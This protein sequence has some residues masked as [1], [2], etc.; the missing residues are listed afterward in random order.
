MN[1]L[2]DDLVD[3]AYEAMTDE[4]EFWRIIGPDA[5][6]HYV[7]VRDSEI[8]MKMKATAIIMPNAADKPTATEVQKMFRMVDKAHAVACLQW[9][10]L[11]AAIAAVKRELVPS[12]SDTAATDTSDAP[13]NAA[14]DEV[15]E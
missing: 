9:H 5:K 7:A 3:R 15:K 11:R 4:L 13:L 10:A 14:N 2:P 12:T 8:Q 6:G 1:E